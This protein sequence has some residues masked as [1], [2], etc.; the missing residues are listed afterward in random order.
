MGLGIGYLIVDVLLPFFIL[1]VVWPY[2]VTPVV[3][4]VVGSVADTARLVA[5]RLMPSYDDRK[6]N[7]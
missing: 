7:Q 4:F 5:S 3:S 2:V 6:K 1:M